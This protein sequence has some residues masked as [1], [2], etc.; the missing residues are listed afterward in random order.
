M[1]LGADIRVA[2]AEA[3]ARKPQTFLVVNG[4][5]YVGVGVEGRRFRAV[6]A[7]I[8]NT[9]VVAVVPATQRQVCI[10]LSDV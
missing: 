1:E 10:E 8:G 6:T 7:D 5:R 3:A 9:R 4:V 2:E